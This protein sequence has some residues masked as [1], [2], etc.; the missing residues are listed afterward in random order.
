MIKNAIIYTFAIDPSLSAADI[1]TRLGNAQ[2]VP[3][4]PT[5][6]ESKGW[7]SPRGLAN[8]PMLEVVAGQWV[9]R[10]TVEVRKVP[11][12][13]VKKR[14]DEL[15]AKVEEETG[16]KP[17]KKYA[18]ELKEQATLELLPQAFTRQASY[19]VWIDREA[20][21]LVV[22]AGS[23]S[24][25]DDVASALVKSLDGL[26]TVQAL[27]TATSP[28]ACM[29][30]WL[31]DGEPPAGFTVDRECELKSNDEMKSVVKYGRHRLDTEEVRQHILTGKTPT[32][33]AMT[34]RD[35]ASFVLTES[36]TIKK[37]TL[38]DVVMEARKTSNPTAKDEA[39]DADVAIM[40]G[41]LQP[42]IADLVDA[43]GGAQKDGGVNP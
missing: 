22:D 20:K 30:A 40:T 36:M 7:T 9:A 12:A 27:Q 5:Q 18:K 35:R 43:L 14:V 13:A 2:F 21:T 41:E 11:G 19:I 24:K 25:A 28:A 26:I 6:Q 17:G 34:W 16:R 10:L 3:C 37:L 8:S 29:A 15:A 4:G 39:F 23:T 33:L 31:S 38:L 32:K 42:L 1:E